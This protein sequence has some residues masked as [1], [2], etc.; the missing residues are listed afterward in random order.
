[1]RKHF[2]ENIQK[3][4]SLEHDFAYPCILIELNDMNHRIFDSVLPLSDIDFAKIK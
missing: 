3:V 1:M 2:L 4:Y